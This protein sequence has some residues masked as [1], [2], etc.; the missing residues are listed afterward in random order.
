MQIKNLLAT[1]DKKGIGKV[2]TIKKDLSS[3][4]SMAKTLQKESAIRS[5]KYAEEAKAKRE[6][7]KQK[8]VEEQQKAV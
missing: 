5:A 4:E 3:L 6:A 2:K 7:T 8:K 1:F